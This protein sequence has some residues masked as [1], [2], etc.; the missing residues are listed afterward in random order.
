MDLF[1]VRTVWEWENGEAWTF[2]HEV[3]FKSF[4]TFNIFLHCQ[5][6]ALVKDSRNAWSGFGA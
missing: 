2:D 4:H 1:I 6:A 5:L 3:N